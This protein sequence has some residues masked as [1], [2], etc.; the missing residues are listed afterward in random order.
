LDGITC[1]EMLYFDIMYSVSCKVINGTKRQ[2]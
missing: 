2:P 1:I